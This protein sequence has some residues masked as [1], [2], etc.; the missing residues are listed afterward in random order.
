MF[1]LSLL[2]L[3]LLYSE[4][5]PAQ[6]NLILNH[7]ITLSDSNQGPSVPVSGTLNIIAVMVEFQPDTNRFTSG[8]GTFGPGSIPYLENPGTN[9]DALPHDRNY[10]EAHLKFVKNYF[11]N[12][13]N[14]RL[15][16]Q[17]QVLPNVYRLANEMA[18]YS[19]VGEDPDLSQ[20]G[21]LVRDVWELVSLDG[22]LNLNSNQMANTAF[23][24]FHAGIGRDIEL[25]GTTLDKTPQ[26]IPSVYLSK[27]ALRNLFVDP[28]FT[29]FQIDNGNILVDNSL[30]LPRT[31][32]RSGE[33]VTGERFVL[34]L[35]TNGMIAAQVASHLGLPDLFNTET[36][37]SGIGQFGLM[38]GAG[39][40]AFNGLF[41][42]GLSAWE[43]I[44]LGWAEPFNIRADQPNTYT[45]PAS[46]FHENESIAKLSLSSSE[47]FLIENRHRDPESD[48]LEITIQKPD[49][50]VV[51]QTFTN[52]DEEFVN[53]SL[54]F[55][56][57]LEPGVVTNVSNFDFALPGGF[58]DGGT[59]SPERELNGGILIWHIDESVIN[60]Q[61]GT[62]GINS[63]PNR[64]GV[65]LV[66]ADGAQDIGKPTQIG[67]GQN[68]SNGSAFD[69]WWSGNNA[70][71]ITQTGN[72]TLYQNR[73][74]ADTT[75]NNNTNSG[76]PSFFELFDFSDNLPIASF[77]IRQV[78]PN[79]AL[80]S[81]YDER[82]DIT[83][84]AYNDAENSYSIRFPLAIQPISGVNDDLIM[85]PGNNGFQFFNLISKS[86]Y[87]DK[88]EKQSTQQPFID[89]MSALFAISENPLNSNELMSTEIYSIRS[90]TVEKLW[91]FTTTPNT[92]FISSA[93]NSILDFDGTNIRADIEN[94]KLIETDTPRKLSQTV[95]GVQSK[96]ENNQL[97]ITAN[98][99][100]V[101]HSLP[102]VSNRFRREHTGIID[103]SGREIFIYLLLDDVLKIFSEQSGFQDEVII[104]DRQLIYWPA[105]ADLNQD[106]NPD[107]AFT[108]HDGTL[109]AINKN[110]G[111]LNNFP[112]RA[113]RDFQFSGTPL[114]ADING[115]GAFE[116]IITAKN[117]FSMNIYAYD[118]NGQIIEG[119][120]LYSGSIAGP[121]LIP[122][123]PLFFDN[124]L[125]SLSPDG[126]LKI[127]EFPSSE[128]VLW[129]SAYG[130]FT[131]NKVSS[132]FL[133][134]P[135]T[136]DYALLNKDETYNW[137]NPAIDETNIRFQTSS[138]AEMS[139]KIATMS[140]RLIYSNQFQSQG[141]SAEEILIDTSSW[142]SGGYFAVVEATSGN[143]TERK[144]IN[145]AIVR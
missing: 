3:F 137:P 138:P 20:L 41:P 13:S 18:H 120:P 114:I 79:S 99:Q 141:I 11:Q 5:L 9:I 51:V 71:V 108:D 82:S 121:N 88:I 66:E 94:F 131:N 126:D 26:D 43:K 61:S 57:L 90:E 103:N 84:S 132:I 78:N 87:P 116:V 81:L 56:R 22:E 91:D 115:D 69:F 6:Q 80:Y 54:G 100:T 39:I 140:G 65:R 72:I 63:N 59:D 50:S 104:S 35:S 89:E 14:G 144:V 45:L 40:F 15:N 113:P 7:T 70:T 93:Q 139:I 130:N 62:S 105:I 136:F 23:V 85:L 31:L 123:N 112:I 125:I 96:I 86:L 133:S 127:W 101:T 109:H 67:L 134:E 124:K 48:G 52:R 118:L 64:R 21:T 33:D 19:P 97:V 17:Y 47:Y 74:G 68:E 117:A 83:I 16:I 46:T 10:F 92:G 75:P 37:E 25:T 107:F 77:S 76:A 135:V 60:Q 58:D 111:T 2:F 143:L 95:R 106:G 119:F 128:N 36:G 28:T 110:G 34:P 1:L 4:H 30:I 32:S 38:D 122:V 29:G 55:D 142:A 44:Y 145:I 8:N 102:S 49:G 12:Q 129:R 24:I 42:P 98:G 53:K 73:F 27:N